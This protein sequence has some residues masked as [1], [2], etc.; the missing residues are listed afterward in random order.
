MRPSFLFLLPW[1]LAAAQPPAGER[2]AWRVIVA[3]DGAIVGT[4]AETR[5][6]DGRETAVEQRVILQ[7]RGDS[8]TPL[9]ERTVTRRGADGEVESIV[10]ERQAGRATT[11]ISARIRGGRAEIERRTSS[12][13]PYRA[14]LTLP[15][16]IR[17]DGGMGLLAGWDRRA[18]PELAFST[19]N[20]EAMAVER[21][22]LSPAPAATALPPGHAA[23]LRRTLEGDSPRGVQL[24]IVGP[25]NRVAETR[26]PMFG[27]AMSIRVATPEEAQRPLVPHRPLTRAMTSSP[28]RLTRS[29]LSGRIRYRFSF[30]DGIAFPLPTTGEQRLTFAEGTATL[31]VCADCGPGLATDPAALAAA[32]QPTAWIQSRDP[33]IQALAD[34]VRFR[35]YS[36]DRRM[37]LLVQIA[38]RQLRGIDFAGH[39]SAVEAIA[40]R[41]GDCTESAVIL[42]ALGRALG[43]PTKVASGL[44]YSRSTYHGASNIFLPHSWVLAYVGGRWRSY[45]SALGAFDASHIALT[46]SDGDARSI[47]AANQLAGLLVW[48]TIEEVRRPP[49]VP[50]QL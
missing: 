34:P 24:L 38:E 39:F 23:L 1:L 29:A 5:S 6:A 46:I 40:R 2:T 7:E 21:V 50:T 16:D 27:S 12:A 22:L 20:I 45:D 32:R 36:D 18:T 42:A 10:R 17:F 47:A 14:T 49:A 28:F 25:D 30:R 9:V 35:A 37:E 31:T 26:Q 19:L 13:P 33:A 3:E 48:Q 44:V 43:I 11:T 15:P 8:A 4:I 41:R